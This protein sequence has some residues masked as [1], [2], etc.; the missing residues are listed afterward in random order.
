MVSGLELA[1]PVRAW[2]ND[3]EVS[4]VPSWFAAGQDIRKRGPVCPVFGVLKKSEDSFDS[5]SEF[6]VEMCSFDIGSVYLWV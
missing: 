6:S 1:V 4:L 3:C 5:G 2:Q